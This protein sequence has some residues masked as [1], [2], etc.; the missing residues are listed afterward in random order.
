MTSIRHVFEWHTMIRPSV[1]SQL[2]ETEFFPKWL[3]V[4]HFWLIQPSLNYEEV[5]QWYLFWK[6]AFPEDI[7]SLTTV[8]RGFER[9]QKLM[10]DAI[11]L[12]KDAPS[13]LPRPDHKHDVVSTPQKTVPPKVKGLVST[14]EGHSPAV[15]DTTRESIR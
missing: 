9:A 14:T 7:R 4:L 15:K 3:D 13:K 12:G 5:A 1:Y 6:G 2:L 8:S 10:N 11:T